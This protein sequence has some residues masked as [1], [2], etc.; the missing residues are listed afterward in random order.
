MDSTHTGTMKMSLRTAPFVVIAPSI[1]VGAVDAYSDV[2]KEEIIFQ[3]A[4]LT[5]AA[6]LLLPAQRTNV[7]AVV[8]KV[9][10]AS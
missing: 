9:A 7:P 8:I 4:D 3:S 10:L 5:L 1:L 2:Q 6:T